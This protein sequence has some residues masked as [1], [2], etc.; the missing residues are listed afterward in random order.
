LH[1]SEISDYL[2]RNINSSFVVGQELSLY[3]ISVDVEKKF[4]SFSYKS[5]HPRF[6]KNPYEF[7]L[8]ETKNKSN[9]LIQNTMKVLKND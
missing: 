9:N 2:V 4:I 8:I 1:I 6:L 7:E 5:I 3:V